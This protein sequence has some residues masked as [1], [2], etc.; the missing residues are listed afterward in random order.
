[1]IIIDIKCPVLALTQSEAD[2][3]VEGLSAE[4]YRVRGLVLDQTDPRSISALRAYV[5]SN[6][7]GLDA[8][9]CN[10]GISYVVCD[11]C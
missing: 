7:G 5:A 11:P 9:I 10:A 6:Y 8:L 1:M 2:T 4:G 3:A